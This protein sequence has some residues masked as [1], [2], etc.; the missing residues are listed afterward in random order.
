[1]V[2]AK[3]R[4]CK[5]FGKSRSAYSRRNRLSTE[6][7]KDINKMIIIRR[8]LIEGIYEAQFTGPDSVK[9]RQAFGTDTLPTPFKLGFAPELVLAAIQGKN[10]NTEVVLEKGEN[11]EKQ[12][13]QKGK[14]IVS[15]ETP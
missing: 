14:K 9:V 1:M 13:R 4:P 15:Q 7:K 12:S 10:R 11:I 5:E 2:E 3:R 8:N 6:K